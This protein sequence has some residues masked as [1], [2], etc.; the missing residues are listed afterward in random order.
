LKRA[1]SG[2]EALFVDNT[3]SCFRL[4]NGPGD[5]IDGLTIDFYAEYIL[6]QYFNTDVLA[7]IES[8]QLDPDG[9]L[10]CLA[11]FGVRIRGI[12]LKN[13]LALKGDLDYGEIRKS[14]LLYGQMPPDEYVVKQNGSLCQ[15]D[16]VEGQSTGI[17]LDMREIRHDLESFYREYSPSAMLNLFCY[18][19][20]F[21]VHALCNG[22]SSAVNVDLS[23]AVLERARKNYILNGLHVDDRDFIYGDA[24]EWVRQFTKKKREF[25]FVVVDPPTFS[26]NRQKTFSVKQHYIPLL[27]SLENIVPDGYV[28]TSINSYTVSYDEYRSYH[29]HGW[30]PLFIGHE[31]SDFPESRNNYLKVGLWKTGGHRRV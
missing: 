14:L 28:L 19:A 12:L 20:L 2:R 23:R 10:E 16:L 29:P 3:T 11:P 25:A 8:R 6:I 4:F 30:E 7:L 15:V 26:R 5:G 13:R 18:T 17:F 31:S 21:S 24:S 27:Q 9:I 1:F 22:V